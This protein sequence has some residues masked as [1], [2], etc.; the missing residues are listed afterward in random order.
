MSRAITIGI[1]FSF[2][3]WKL[4]A[5]SLSIWWQRLSGWTVESFIKDRRTIGKIKILFSQ[6][7]SSNRLGV[8]CSTMEDNRRPARKLL[9]LFSK[10]TV[11]KY[12]L[13]IQWQ[14]VCVL[15]F[16]HFI[17]FF[18]FNRFFFLRHSNE[19]WTLILN[20]VEKVFR[21][22]ERICIRTQWCWIIWRVVLSESYLC[23]DR[24]RN[25]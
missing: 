4:H 6:K 24:S 22:E 5:L 7:N 25:I 8:F 16:M 3:S 12:K 2:H 15:P 10:R 17:F 20:L 14:G 13:L 19:T 1:F 23:I 9:L 11:L 18:F 21:E